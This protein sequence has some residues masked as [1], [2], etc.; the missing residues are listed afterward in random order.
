MRPTAP[1][2][3][4]GFT[5]IELLVVIAIIAIL[6]S[7]LFPV[8]SRA[9]AKARQT[10]CLSNEK[11][12]GLALMM[13]ADDSDEALPP[14]S[15][16]GGG[17]SGPAPAAGVDPYTWD[18][19]IQPYARNQQILFCADNPY[20]RYRSYA[21]PR[22]I[23]AQPI[24]AFPNTTATVLLFEKGH[25]APGVWD[26]ATGENFNQSTTTSATGVYFHNEGKSFLFA[27]GHAKWYVKNAGPFLAGSS[28][29]QC[30]TPGVDWPQ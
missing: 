23:S 19:I 7:I 15:Q 17:A 22:Y 6:A 16:V 9:R 29:G 8:F 26:D 14:W 3:V 4:V 30:E 11:Q 2:R 13:Y 1:V 27:D 21:Y 18:A 5:L 10:S 28:P 24:G 20:G 25:Y 12:L